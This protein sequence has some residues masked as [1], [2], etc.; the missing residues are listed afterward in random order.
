MVCRLQM[1]G[2]TVL[3]KYKPDTQDYVRTMCHCK[4]CNRVGLEKQRTAQY[5]Q[6]IPTSQ[7]TNLTLIKMDCSIIPST[8]R[9]RHTTVVLAMVEQNKSRRSPFCYVAMHIA[10]RNDFHWW[11]ASTTNPNASEM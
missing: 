2:S 6:Q 8:V 4:S 7:R 9:Q 11:L 3:S 1:A 5:N 10:Q